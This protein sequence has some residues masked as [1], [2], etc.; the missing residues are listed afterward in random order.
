MVKISALFSNDCRFC[1]ARVCCAGDKKSNCVSPSIQANPFRPRRQTVSAM[2]CLSVARKSYVAEL[3]LDS[4]MNDL[5]EKLKTQQADSPSRLAPGLLNR[6]PPSSRIT[7]RVQ[8][9]VEWFL[10]CSLNAAAGNLKT[11]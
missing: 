4:L 7:D 3:A 5:K 11:P 8:R 9:L 1:S 6:L 10:Q 2:S